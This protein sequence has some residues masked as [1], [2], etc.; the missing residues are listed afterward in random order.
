MASKMRQISPQMSRILAGMHNSSRL[1]PRRP[2]NSSLD[3][4][5]AQEIPRSDEFGLQQM[6]RPAGTISYR[7]HQ[8]F[9]LVKTEFGL[10]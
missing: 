2:D 3:T 4:P 1:L 6:D 10:Q 7:R 8:K 5:R 9:G